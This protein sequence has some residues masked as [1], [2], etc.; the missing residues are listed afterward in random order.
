MA[1]TVSCRKCNKR[2]K[3]GYS[4]KKHRDTSHVNSEFNAGIFKDSKDMTLTWKPSAKQLEGEELASYKIWL[5]LLCEQI[6]GSL[7]PNVKGKKV[8]GRSNI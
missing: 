1:F 2:F 6:T 7:N 8:F 3:T 5:A 4:V